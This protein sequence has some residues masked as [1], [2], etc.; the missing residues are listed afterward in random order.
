M[1]MKKQAKSGR[2]VALAVIL[3]G[4]FVIAVSLMSAQSGMSPAP[5]KADSVPAPKTAGEV[6]KNIKV[7]KDMPADQLL[8]AMQ[9]ITG[10][11]GTGCDHCHVEGHFDQ[12]DKKPKEIARK[13]MAMMFAINKDNFNGRREVTCNSCHNG[14]P[15]PAGVPVIGEEMAKAAPPMAPPEGKVDLSKLPSAD[16]VVDKFVQ[17]VGGEA[18]AEKIT[19]RVAT[20]TTTG[21]GGRKFPLQIFDEM[22]DKIALFTHYPMGDSV[23]GYNGQEG[24]TSF[25]RRPAR[26]MEGA[27]L[28][29]AK[30]DA[31]LHLAIDLKKI[32][33]ELKVAPP[34]KIGDH[35]AYK[36]LGMRPGLPPVEFYFDED[37]GLL[38]REVRYAQS[39]LGLYPT[40]I[41]YSDYREQDGV[42]IPFSWTTSHPRDSAT[43]Q[44]EQV[45]QNVPIDA[46]KFAK[47]APPP[48]N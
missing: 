48:G 41:D 5:E 26:E 24:W 25:P 34:Q 10:A 12:D 42:K 16:T 2:A 21:F 31:N 1:S 36:I 19:S 17:A 32:F 28:D 15:E 39:P 29:A 14:S 3:G 43:V 47:P 35:E 22:P 40:R 27:D 37:S 6:Y 13:M 11:L 33:S 9:F 38:V 46:A 23:T 44:L 20:G 45:Q 7:L 18:A 8:P 4:V 30:L